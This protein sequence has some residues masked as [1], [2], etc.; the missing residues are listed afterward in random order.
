MKKQKKNY[1]NWFA[2]HYPSPLQDGES[3][4]DKNGH[5]TAFTTSM[6]ENAV[7]SG[8]PP[9]K[10]LVFGQMFDY[11]TDCTLGQVPFLA[12]GENYCHEKHFLKGK[13]ADDAARE[14][15]RNLRIDVFSRLIIDAI[16]RKSVGTRVLIIGVM[17]SIIFPSILKEARSMAIDHFKEQGIVVEF[18]LQ[19]IISP[20]FCSVIHGLNQEDLAKMDNA[21]MQSQGNLLRGVNYFQTTDFTHL[22]RMSILI[23]YQDGTPLHIS[24]IEYFTRF[25]DDILQRAKLTCY[26][27]LT[28]FHLLSY[29]GKKG[30]EN[31]LGAM[32]AEER[33]AASEK[34]YENGL[35][36]MSAEERMTAS[37]KGYENG[38]GMMSAEARMAARKKGYE[39]GLG[40]AAKREWTEEV[41]A[42]IIRMILDKFSFAKI[43]LKLGNGLSKND[44]QHRWDRKLRK[45]SGITKPAVQPVQPGFPSRITWTADADAM[46]ERMKADGITYAEIAA[47]LGNGLS[48]NDIVNRWNRHLKNKLQ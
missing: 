28:V 33:M 46:I 17:P 37:E 23:D 11:F 48:K 41:D 1:E 15:W 30:Y 39:N 26:E 7:N 38:I 25:R 42:S 35:G 18:D 31:G 19:F 5:A 34:G 6:Y 2:G 8:L 36:A 29:M 16:N 10:Q 40:K 12:G 45:S 24:M 21:V 9:D 27:E 4:T 32:S 47:E 13:L 3:Y 20:H 44:V 43:A 14:H 22:H